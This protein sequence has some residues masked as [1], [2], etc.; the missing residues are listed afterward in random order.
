MRRIQVGTF[1]EDLGQVARCD[2]IIQS[3]FLDLTQQVNNR[4]VKSKGMLY[5]LV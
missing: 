1:W 4:G 5:G 2:S 3:C